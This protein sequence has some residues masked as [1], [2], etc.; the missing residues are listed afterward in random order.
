MDD[1]YNVVERYV[2][3]DDLTL[4][5]CHDFEFIHE[6]HSLLQLANARHDQYQTSTGPRPILEGVIQAIDIATKQIIFEWHSLDHIPINESCLG[7][8][9][10]D[11]LYVK[12]LGL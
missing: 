5:D 11:Y 9:L 3:S 4:I 2:S 12:C 6:G 10:P 8:E 7:L 1:R